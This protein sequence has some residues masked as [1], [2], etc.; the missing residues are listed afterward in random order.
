MSVAIT[1]YKLIHHVILSQAKN[2]RSEMFRFAQHD[3]AIDLI[4]SSHA[5]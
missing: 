5:S 3:N 2:L 4:K 1:M